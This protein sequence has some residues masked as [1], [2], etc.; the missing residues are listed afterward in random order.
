MTDDSELPVVRQWPADE[1][2][3]PATALS[4]ECPG[5]GAPWRIH[6]DLAGFRVRC[7][8]GSYVQAPKR[9]QAAGDP[10]AVFVPEQAHLPVPKLTRDNEGRLEVPHRRG[11]TIE[12]ELP[13]D[14]PMAPG[15]VQHADVPTRQRWTTRAIL[16]LVLFMAAFL[17]PQFCIGFFF[18]GE[19]RTLAMPFASLVTGVAVVLLAAALNPY[20]FS[21]V[22]GAKARYWIEAVLFAVGT[23][24]LAT[25]WVDLIDV[26][27]EGGAML[28]AWREALGPGWLLFVLAFCPAVFE[29]LAF[30]GAVQGRFCALLG[31]YEG[32]IA[33]GAAF[34]LCHGITAAL[35]F[36][37]GIGIY[38][39]FLRSRSRSLLPCI[40]AHALY[41][42][43]IGLTA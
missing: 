34:G 20:V 14:A 18:D 36:H 30:R 37:V 39:C 38:L 28:R 5:C 42:G 41:N 35:P 11:E 26:N 7:S 40:A 9:A 6:P 22:R 3:D 33:T 15:T 1:E 32:I 12:R 8:C 16:E 4:A 13:V 25:V 24:F 21:G 31:Y 43:L 17:L 29:E 27:D 19:A 2:L 23:Y 10:F